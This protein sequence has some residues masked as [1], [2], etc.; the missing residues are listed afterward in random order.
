MFAYACRY[1]HGGLMYCWQQFFHILLRPYA[2]KYTLHMGKEREKEKETDLRP[3]Q[4]QIYSMPYSYINKS[5]IRT[6][7][8]KIDWRKYP[9]YPWHAFALL[10][11]CVDTSHADFCTAAFTQTLDFS[12]CLIQQ[13]GVKHSHWD[14]NESCCS[15]PDR[16]HGNYIPPGKKCT[17][18]LIVSTCL[19][20]NSGGE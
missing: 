12:I 2:H 1:R 3:T 18:W 9:K 15:N 17:D 5:N 8:P 16:H 14:T 19:L 10:I 6:R 13:V 11:I 7:W 4:F 20:A